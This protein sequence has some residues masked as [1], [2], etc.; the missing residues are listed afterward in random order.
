MGAVACAAVGQDRGWDREGLGWVLLLEKMLCG[1]MMSLYK[2]SSA[3]LL[4]HDKRNYPSCGR[5]LLPARWALGCG[6][7]PP[8]GRRRR[9]RMCW[10][11]GTHW[12]GVFC[13]LKRRETGRE[14]R[15]GANVQNL[16][17]KEIFQYDKT[18]SDCRESS[19]R[20]QRL[21]SGCHI[22]KITGGLVCAALTA[23]G[24]VGP[25][26]CSCWG[27]CRC[28]STRTEVEAL[29]E[30]PVLFRG[31]SLRLSLCVTAK[32]NIPPPGVCC[33]WFPH[34]PLLV[35]VLGWGG[36]DAEHSPTWKL[37]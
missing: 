18:S 27:L 29:L 2:P 11:V 33:C 37:T 22:E 4:C 6:C 16:E 23:C 9:G 15:R 19:R 32:R 5:K 25:L 20:L 17:E 14:E 28:W 35:T 13:W 3:V 8:L 26:R 36:S 12:K 30:E 10:G 31:R 7:Q 34:M 21:G 1:M 24:G